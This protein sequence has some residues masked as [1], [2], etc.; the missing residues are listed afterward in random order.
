M[1][2]II[3][4]GLIQFLIPLFWNT[5]TAMVIDAHPNL[6]LAIPGREMMLA[7]GRFLG[8]LAVYVSFLLEAQPVYIFILLGIVMLLYPLNLFWNVKI[9]KEYSYL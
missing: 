3:L 1:G 4:S 8:L 6:K 7:S 2:W 5:S 9:K